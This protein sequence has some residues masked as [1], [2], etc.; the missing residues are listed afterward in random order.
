[1]KPPD[2]YLSSNIMKVQLGNGHELWATSLIDYVKKN[3]IVIVECLLN[4]LLTEEPS[5]E[6]FSL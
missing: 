6:S 4:R 2:I 5:K 1:M 3:V